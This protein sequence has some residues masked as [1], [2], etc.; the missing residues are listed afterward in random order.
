MTFLKYAASVLPIKAYD[1]AGPLYGMML[2]IL[3][4]LSAAPVSFCCCPRLASVEKAAIRNKRTLSQCKVA[5][6]EE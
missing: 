4:S 3:I 1:D 2:P 5:S 6:L